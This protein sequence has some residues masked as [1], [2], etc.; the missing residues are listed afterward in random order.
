MTKWFRANTHIYTGWQFR[1]APLPAG[2]A[3]RS[4]SKKIFFTGKVAIPG[5]KLEEYSKFME[6]A[7][8]RIAHSLRSLATGDARR[9]VAKA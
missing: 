9:W 2:C 8:E 1:C 4:V 3:D 5:D 7:E 6:Q